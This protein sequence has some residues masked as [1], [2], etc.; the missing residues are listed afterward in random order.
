M[1]DE[2]DLVIIKHK[3][4]SLIIRERWEVSSSLLVLV[5]VVVVVE[6]PS[7]LNLDLYL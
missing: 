6:M 5:V 2:N 1:V 7:M 4:S 3:D